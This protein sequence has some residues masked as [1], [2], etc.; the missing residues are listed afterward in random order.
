MK[1]KHKFCAVA[2]ILLLGTL[3]CS[4]Q[5]GDYL[6]SGSEQTI[7]LGPGLYDIT[8]YGAQGG[9]SGGLG[10]EMEA[11][12]SFAAAVNLTVLIGGTGT[13]AGET[14]GGGGDG[15]GGGGFSGNGS[16]GITYSAGGQGYGG[17]GFLAGGAGGY[18]WSGT[19]FYGY[20]AIT[21]A[22]VVMEEAE[23]G[24]F[25]PSA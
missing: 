6:Y 11:Q 13:F 16:G 4:A 20:P 15:G 10:A 12:F 18:G 3:V 2:V 23:E 1:A 21:A 9:A 17:S 25:G 5:T 14:G 8:A 22:T 19:N 7:T 24:A